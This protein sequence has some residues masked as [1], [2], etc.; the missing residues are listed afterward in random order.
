MSTQRVLQPV[1]D[2]ILS[3]CGQL[4]SFWLFP[5]ILGWIVY[6]S[7]GI[8]FSVKDIGPWR[9]ERTRIHKDIWPSKSKV[10]YIGGIQV[11]LYALMNIFF[12]FAF[13]YFVKMPK[14]AP[15]LWEVG[16][17]FCIS[18]L[19][20]DF[21]IYLDHVLHHKVKFLYRN[22]HYVHHRFTN[23][24]FSWCAGWVN[25]IE[26]LVFAFLLML[27]PWL[28]FP[29][30][31]LSLWIFEGV[32]IALFLEEHS[33]HDVW[34]SPHNWVPSIFGGAVPH[35]LHHTKL[36]VNFGF[37]FAIWDRT[38]GTYLPPTKAIE[39]HK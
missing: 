37:V 7:V 30:H 6:T 10:L 38:F 27:Y 9:S 13:P 39:N 20:G 8:Y 33:G 18:M 4:V 23:D 34:W 21:L 26:N 19:I 22:I 3:N 25:P 32:F 11:I 17:D 2:C 12:W 24:L 5:I 16:R 1:W 31:P 29:I 28:L 14:E 36:K 35:E 15:T